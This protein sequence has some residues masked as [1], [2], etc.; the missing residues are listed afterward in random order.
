M[1]PGPGTFPDQK[2]LFLYREEYLLFPE[3]MGYFYVDQKYEIELYK[4][5]RRDIKVNLVLVLET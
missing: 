5:G 2:Q 1:P 3:N 4:Q